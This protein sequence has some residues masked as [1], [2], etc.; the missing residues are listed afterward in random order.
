MKKVEKRQNYILVSGDELIG[1]CSAIQEICNHIGIS[2]SW[3]YSFKNKNINNDGTWSFNYKGYNYTIYTS[4]YFKSEYRKGNEF[5]RQ[6]I[7]KDLEKTP[8]Q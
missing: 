6:I 3:L 1:T 5:I 7:K 2:F 4:E 8:I